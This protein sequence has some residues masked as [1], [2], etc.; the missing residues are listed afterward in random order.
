MKPNTELVKLH[1]AD[2]QREADRN[3]LAALVRRAA[4]CCSPR[5][6]RQRFAAAVSSFAE[7]CCPTDQTFLARAFRLIQGA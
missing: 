2:R 5:S 7:A 3:R 1:M 4:A 6:I